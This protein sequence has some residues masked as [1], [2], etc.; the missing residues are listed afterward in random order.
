M[1][2]TARW[3]GEGRKVIRLTI[4]GNWSW[5]EFYNTANN[6]IR[7]MEHERTRINFILEAVTEYVPFEALQQLEAASGFFLHPQAGFAVVVGKRG[8]LRKLV[9]MLAHLYP[10][11]AQRLSY[12]ETV[13]EAR[14]TLNE[15]RIERP[16]RF[17]YFEYR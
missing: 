8:Y 11:A 6:V 16:T 13:D 1:P 17:V 5:A 9:T 7:M 3:D 2:V 4:D 10:N 14:M 15:G 12:A